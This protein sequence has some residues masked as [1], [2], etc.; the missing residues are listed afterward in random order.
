MTCGAVFTFRNFSHFSIRSYWFYYRFNT[1]YWND[2]TKTEFLQ[3]RE[4]NL[5]KCFAYISKCVA[6]FITIKLCIRKFSNTNS[7]KNYYDKII[8]SKYD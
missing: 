8:H 5:A 6:S 4:I 3:S 7:I 1:V 2:I